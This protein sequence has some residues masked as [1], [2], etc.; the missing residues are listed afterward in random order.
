MTT[1]SPRLSSSSPLSALLMFVAV[2][3][4]C[5]AASPLVAQEEGADDSEQQDEQ[6]DRHL[7]RADEA[8]HAGKWNEALEA[9]EKAYRAAPEQSAR[10]V[11]AALGRSTLLWEQGQYDA[12]SKFIGEALELAKQQ[13]LHGAVGRLLLT[14]GHTQASQGR[15]GEAEQTLETCVTLAAEQDDPVFG[16]LCK[17]NRRLVRKLQGKDV[18]SEEDYERALQRLE[19]VGS[20][21]TA[22]LSLA[23]TAELYAD[24]GQRGRAF[25][26]LDRAG[27]KYDEA[28]SVPA[29]ARNR[30]LQARLLQE[31]G[32]WKVARGK[33]QGL[34]EKFESM[35]SKP[36]IFDVLGLLGNDAQH[37]GAF[38]KSR[39]YYDRALKVAKATGSPQLIAKARAAL[40]DLGGSTGDASVDEQCRQAAARFEQ[41]G[42]PK[43]AAQVHASRGRLA[44]STGALEKAR[45]QFLAVREMLQ[46]KVHPELREP[47]RTREILANLCQVEMKLESD[48]AHY[49]CREALEE[50]QEADSPP[51]GMVASTR[52]AL[53]NAAAR[54]GHREE[55]I[56]QLEKAGEMFAA[57]DSS[58][59]A[60]LGDVQ[61]R[62]GAMH[63]EAGDR[64]AAA[65][66]FRKGVER[67]AGTDDEALS[68]TLV[69]LRSQYAQVELR[70]ENWESVA[71]QLPKVADEAE[72]IGDT[73]TRAWSLSALARAKNKLG[74]EEEA[75][76][77]LDQ[78]L[79][80]AREAGDEK[81]IETIES[82]LEAFSE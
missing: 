65:K 54:A 39:S 25:D 15:I 4:A 81:L 70:R 72:A 14:L 82:N 51:E 29:K 57:G 19:A 64:E 35:G 18:G 21:L 43:I 46:D 66:A 5:L 3:G 22:G 20:P 1:I 80:L 68:T 62:L 76:E 71:K 32:E 12:A 9:Y 23:K 37:R 31:N 55:G 60:M 7:D 75:R 52:Y 41:L 77:A 48:G 11:E 16:P 58:D 27:A 10:R 44:Q 79:P 33:L 42:M 30:M 78:A 24:G 8:Y 36:A 69:Q 56:E 61:L 59:R 74:E 6:V 40:C 45:D 17:L 67:L 63:Q 73:A 47:S 49:R 53:G 2:I 50:L 38:E 34:L 13:E 28:G 26:L